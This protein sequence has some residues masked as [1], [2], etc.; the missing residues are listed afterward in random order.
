M[1]S[2]ARQVLLE[3]LAG[4]Y[5][6]LPAVEAVCLGG[7][8]TGHFADEQSDVDLYVYVRESIALSERA[9]IAGNAP[10]AEI[11]N[12][13]WEPGDEWRDPLSG[14]AVDVMFRHLNWMEGQL[15][16]V[17]VQHQASVGYSTCFWYNV[18]HS[19][20]LFDL[21]WFAALQERARA[22]YPEPLVRAII[23]MNHPVLRRNQ[24]SYLHQVELAIARHDPVSVQHRVTALL[25]SYF[26]VLFALN[27]QPHPGEKRLL[28]YAEALC[29]ARPSTM[30]EDVQTLLVALPAMDASIPEAIHR[31]VDGLD[32]V[33]ASQTSR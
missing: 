9:V 32:A 25:A 4:R 3:Q 30:S 6:A 24:S 27:R 28:P 2:Q 23:Q 21:G 19:Q 13:T 10:G 29:P 15:D 22:P 20:P 11:G 26:D 33:L 8:R 1:S 31:L 18:L 7:S 16:R 12:Q 14:L 17:L 5:A